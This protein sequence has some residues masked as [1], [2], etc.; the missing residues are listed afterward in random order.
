MK[1]L[2]LLAYL[3]G[4]ACGEVDETEYPE[5]AGDPQLPPRG[6]NTLKA[7][8]ETGA[9]LTWNCELTGHPARPGSPHDR[10]R[11]CTNDALS[12]APDGPFPVGAASVKELLDGDRIDGYAVMRK[13][14]ADS[15]GGEGWY[16]WEAFGDDVKF[17]AHGIGVCV[18]CHKDAPRDFAFTVVR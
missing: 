16:W 12:N 18:D 11:I 15:R 10:N 9:Y 8:I 17:A 5:E 1:R 3:L 7:W 4:A 2:F 6:P 13:V 14:E